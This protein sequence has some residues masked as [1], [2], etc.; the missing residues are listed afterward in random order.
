MIVKYTGIIGSTVAEL[1]DQTK[2][3]QVSEIVID[4]NKISLAAI[5]IGTPFWSFQKNKFVL[6]I[7][8]VH[9]L[10]DGVIIN[11]I[12]SVINLGESINLEKIVRE[13]CFGIGQ[14]VETESG[15]FLG[16]VYDFLIETDT[17]L[18]TKFYIRHL[19]SERIIPANKIIYMD[20]KSIKIKDNFTTNKAES[21][22]VTDP[23]PAN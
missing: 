8:I 17:L 3:G 2:I 9:L 7:D 10:K 12:N 19:L 22:A 13:K 18:I 23:T 14:R 20:S 1:R 6:A 11:S 16:K 21:I 4:K 15:V 5:A